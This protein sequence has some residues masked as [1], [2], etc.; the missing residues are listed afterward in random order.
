MKSIYIIGSLRNPAIVKIGNK[1]NKLGI[2]A[3]TSWFAAGPKADDY[4]KA[5][6]KARGQSYIT[7]LRDYAS[8]HVYNFDLGHLHRCDAG[9]LVLPAGRSCHL[10]LGYI[11]GLG[12]PG[13][14]LLDKETIKDR[15]DQMLN[16]ATEIFTSQ[17]EMLEYLKCLVERP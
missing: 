16:F 11:R 13:Y 15:W 7:A 12:K 5:Y 9:L 8:Q 4:W 1:I 2:E 14:V 3:F 17:K 10:E 6:S